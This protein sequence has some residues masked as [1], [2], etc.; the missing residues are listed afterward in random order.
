MS[1]TDEHD[2]ADVEPAPP[3][4]PSREEIDLWH[5][6]FGAGLFNQTWELIETENRTADEDDEMLAAAFA[7]R[8]HWGPIG[9]ASNHATGDWQIA[10]VL[11]LLGHGELAVRFAE[12]ALRTVESAGIGDYLLASAF[13]GV[14]RAYA[15]AGNQAERDRYVQLASQA[16]DQ[17]ADP[18]DR[19][20]IEEQLSTVP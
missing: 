4:G 15:A 14:A 2:A 10:H 1:D 20:V 12:K 19:K 16:L 13:E 5:R 9:D 11:S 3:S 17:I 6:R 18:E 7:S 8:L